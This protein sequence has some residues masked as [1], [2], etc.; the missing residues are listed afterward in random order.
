M[1]YHRITQYFA[2]VW[3]RL[4]TWSALAPLVA[5][6]LFLG[7]TQAQAQAPPAPDN[8]WVF[9]DQD[10]E[11]AAPTF[12][13]AAGTLSGGVE[14]VTDDPFGGGGSVSFDG[15]DGIVTME[16]L[17]EAFNG[18]SQF[19]L[20]LWIRSNGMSQDRGFWEA[21][22]SGGADAWG[23]RYDSTG[24]NAGGSNVFKVGITT[25][26]SNG[27]VNRNQ[28]QQESH[29]GAQTTEWQHVAFTWDDGAGFK[30]YIDGV[31]DE[32]TSA[33]QT[34]TGTLDRMDRFV[35]GDGAKAYWDGL[36]DEVAV[37]RAVLTAENIEWLSNNSVTG[38]T[39]PQPPSIL[40][41]IPASGVSFYAADDG[42]SFRLTSSGAIAT[43]RV[44]LLLNGID[45]SGDLAF[46]GDPTDLEATFSRL[47]P[48]Q[49][50]RTEIRTLNAVGA[51]R[52][53]II[54]FDTFSA[55]NPTVEV[56]NWN[57]DGGG[58]IDDP[59]ISWQEA[60]SYIDRGVEI[61][62]QGVDFMEL[63]TDEGR[64]NPDEW[65]IPFE[66]QSQKCDH[67][68]AESTT[69]ANNQHCLVQ[70][71]GLDLV[72][73]LGHARAHVPG[74]L[75]AFGSVIE[76]FL[77]V[78]RVFIGKLGFYLSQS[79]PFEFPFVVFPEHRSFVENNIPAAQ[80]EFGGLRGPLHVATVSD[81]DRYPSK[82]FR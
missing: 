50:Y 2:S 53:K 54:I 27:N 16:D 13:A 77:Q 44:K 4:I 35:I 76:V 9:S 69:V 6:C 25:S 34:T 29:E 5:L 61:G 82:T 70:M 33:M 57:Y 39:D 75:T 43:E 48:N 72:H 30:L 20:S 17:G 51:V 58:F 10:G 38:A 7:Q 74:G 52:S 23:L 11:T 68:C 41:T 47:Q 32:P 21:V 8:G 55:D 59:M 26:E 62:V 63:N 18:E 73:Y 66:G 79:H 40:D 49:I 36:I 31:L 3:Q 65:R 71:I 24:A 78:L 80:S 1:K 42:L 67:G 12:G 22:D 46:S 15:S 56:E 19:T 60:N 45:V 81:V 14:W 37:W 28:E 64:P